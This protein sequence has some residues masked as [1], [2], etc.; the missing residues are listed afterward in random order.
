MANITLHGN[1]VNTVGELPKVGTVAKDFNLVQADLS[2][3]K[4]SDYKGKN[5]VLNIFP[6]LD[7]STCASSVRKFNKDASSLNNTVVLCV[8][9]DLPFAAGRFCTTEGLSDVYT[10]SVFRDTDFGKDYGVQFSDGPLA[11]LLSRAVV[12]VDPEGK[13]SYT[14]QVSEI[15]DEPDY[16]SALAALK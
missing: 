2:G 9:A 6:S 1:P 16:N 14:Q 4:L 12:V 15:A 10:A 11:G 7:T 13:V 8:S 3:I 5:V